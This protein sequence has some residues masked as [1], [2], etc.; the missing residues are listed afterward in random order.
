[1]VLNHHLYRTGD[2][3]E[4]FRNYM[5]ERRKQRNNVNVNTT[6][7]SVSVL[8]SSSSSL[9]EGDSKGD[10]DI[11]WK[12]YPRKVAKI[13]ARQAWAKAKDKPD[14]AFV[15]A[16]LEK[17]KQSEQWTKDGGQFIPHPATWLNQGRWDDEPA[18]RKVLRGI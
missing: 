5:R 10:F 7:T 4:Y 13:A 16:S 12:A 6:L 9:K 2:R 3:R 18:E 14:I 15:V 11:F 1:M 17:Q 8:S